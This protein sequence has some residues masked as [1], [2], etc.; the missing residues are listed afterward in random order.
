MSDVFQIVKAADSKKHIQNC[1]LLNPAM[2]ELQRMQT[3]EGGV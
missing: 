3:R 1:C 2:P